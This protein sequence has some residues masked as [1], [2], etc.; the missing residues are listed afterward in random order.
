MANLPGH[1]LRLLQ[2]A[3]CAQYPVILSTSGYGERGEATRHLL[4]RALQPPRIAHSPSQA[5][6]LVGNIDWQAR[7]S[8]GSPRA[9]TEGWIAYFAYEY[10]QSIWPQ[11]VALHRPVDG[12]VCV[13][14]RVVLDA[15]EEE[16]EIPWQQGPLVKAEAWSE[17][18]ARDFLDGI[19]RIQ[20]YLLDGDVY[21]VNLSRRWQAKTELSGAEIYARLLRANA[22]PFAARACFPGIE[23]IS[24]SPERLFEV[25]NQEIRTQPIA[26]TR[27]RGWDA[28]RD[29]ALR[30]ELIQSPKERAEHIMLVDLERNDLGRICEPGSVKVPRLMAI[31]PYAT[32]QHIVSDV[33]GQLR[34]NVGLSEILQAV[35]PGGTITGCPK[36]HCMELL[37]KLE[38]HAR[39]AYTGSIGYCLDDGQADFN[40]LI[41]TIQK[42]ATSIRLDAGA[43]IVAGCDPAAELEETRAKAR[44]V[45]TALAVAH[46]GALSA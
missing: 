13:V 29:E 5:A 6:E 37:A 22:A 9:G 26:G 3:D 43:G 10:A 20:K 8:H 16:A 31:E 32:V 39:M 35:F 46:M 27:P 44:G 1:R 4:F 33:H 11:K 17:D 38:S 18:P 23:I 15:I 19:E 2:Q 28:S 25:R 7:R 40:I 45:I 36:L 14:Q 34:N 21:Q 24:S 41:R 42:S 30:S 12:P